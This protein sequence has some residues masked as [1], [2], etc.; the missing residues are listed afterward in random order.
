[1]MTRFTQPDWMIEHCFEYSHWRKITSEK[2]FQ[3]RSGLARFN[4]SNP[5]VSIVIPVWNEEK[6][7]MRT[8]SSFSS[9]RL[10]VP[11]ELIFINNNYSVFL[12]NSLFIS[13][14]STT[15]LFL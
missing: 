15:L 2:L 11:A 10:P 5:L 9:M 6:N 7:I 4:S 3:I 12:F 13:V 8:L 1:M 14:S